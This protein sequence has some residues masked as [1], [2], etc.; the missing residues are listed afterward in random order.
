MTKNDDQN[1]PAN[2]ASDHLCFDLVHDRLGR[3]GTAWASQSR[4]ENGATTIDC[5]LQIRN[6]DLG[7]SP[8]RIQS[9]YAFNG[10]G[11]LASAIL[12]DHLG[13]ETR[14]CVDGKLLEINDQSVPLTKPIDLVMENNQVALRVLLLQDTGLEGG[15]SFHC[16]LPETG[17]LL[18]YTIDRQGSEMTDNFGQRITLETDGSVGTIKP[19]GSD[20]VFTRA[21]RKFPSWTLDNAE[22]K[23]EYQR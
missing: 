6:N 17:S 19:P 2:N 1:E 4:G 11:H 21:K 12:K 14:Y 23:F 20:F 22:R 10:S 8:R 15:S 13:N 18:D 16:L 9:S 7:M 3:L 5:R